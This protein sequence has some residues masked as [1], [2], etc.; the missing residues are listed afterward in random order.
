M[1]VQFLFEFIYLFN[2]H[3]AFHRQHWL[4]YIPGLLISQQGHLK[5]LNL[6]SMGGQNF[7]K[8]VSTRMQHYIMDFDVRYTDKGLVTIASGCDGG[9][10][11]L[12]QFFITDLL[13]TEE[14]MN[15]ENIY[16]AGFS[17]EGKISL[18]LFYILCPLYFTCV[19]I[20]SFFY[21]VISKLSKVDQL[22]LTDEGSFHK[23][24][25]FSIAEQNILLIDYLN[26]SHL[27]RT[28]KRKYRDIKEIMMV[29]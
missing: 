4:D 20:S 12:S 19:L 28:I 6:M 22:I 1:H 13:R 8:D 26:L 10:L 9:Q 18:K 24:Y 3:D 21:V 15:R 14:T 7:T 29:K 27:N 5:M 23:I 2:F 16:V 17:T 11:M 25:L